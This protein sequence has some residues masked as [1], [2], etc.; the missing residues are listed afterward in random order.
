MADEEIYHIYAPQDE[1]A[2]TEASRAIKDRNGNII[3]ETYA[4]ESDMIKKAACYHSSI[5]I[6]QLDSQTVEE[7]VEGNFSFYAQYATEEPHNLMQTY[8]VNQ[9]DDAN[10]EF[11]AIIANNA[12][13]Q[14]YVKEDDV[15]TIGDSFTYDLRAISGVTLYRH[16][17]QVKRNS[18][19]MYIDVISTFADKVISFS[20]YHDGRQGLITNTHISESEIISMHFYNGWMM[21]PFFAFTDILAFKGIKYDTSISTAQTVEYAANIFN[22]GA[23][24]VF[25]SDNVTQI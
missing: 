2:D 11:T 23:E 3:D 18:T 17:I 25:V 6:D 16:H 20:P 19:S 4:K 14:C 22:D 8:S 5:A 12:I 15:W 10:I 24:W 7:I 13:R 9:I 21:M 1:N